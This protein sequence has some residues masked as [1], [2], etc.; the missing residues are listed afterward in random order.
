MAHNLAQVADINRIIAQIN[1]GQYDIRPEQFY[2]RMLLDTIKLGSEHYVHLRHTES[3]TLPKGTKKI[4]KRRWGGLTAHTTP[5]KEGIPPHPDKTSMESITFSATAFGRYMEFT[6]RVNLDQIDP[7]LAHYTKELGDV[8]VR[9]LERYAR[10]TLLSAATKLYANNRSG[11]GDLQI[12]DKITI[13]DLRLQ[14]L[15]MKRMLVKPLGDGYFN[16]ICSP[17]FLYDFLDDPLVSKYMSINQTTKNLFDN[18]E[19]FPMFGIK[20]IPTMLDEFYTPELDHPGEFVEGGVTKLRIVAQD[21]TD[22]YYYN[23]SE[24]RSVASSLSYLADGTAIEG[25]VT[26]NVN[27]LLAVAGVEDDSSTP[28]VDETV[29]EVV[30]KVT[31]VD[32]D[33][34][35]TQVDVT[36]DIKDLAWAQLPVHRGI[37]YGKDALVK[38]SIAGEDSAKTYV[39]ALGSAGVLDPIH[40]RQT[41]GCKINSIGYG[42][43]RDEAVCVTFSVPSQAL[44]TS[45]LTAEE[46]KMGKSVGAADTK[47]YAIDGSLY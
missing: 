31:K 38:I 16:Y 2:D 10:Q 13:A 22:T 7:Q 21:G 3:Y 20:F 47:D 36:Q 14:T 6:D 26:W 37:L 43:L 4:Q 28:D 45:Y 9:T 23:A 46:V 33:G 8:M 30:S 18:G 39:Q 24:G 19:A 25:K 34:V 12:G 42:I 17:E 27:L 29:L 32:K 41:I 5:L 35:V 1:D 15:R 11:F 44:E 40:Q